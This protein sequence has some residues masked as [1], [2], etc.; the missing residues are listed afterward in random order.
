MYAPEAVSRLKQ[1][2]ERIQTGEN[3]E[4]ADIE[5]AR[6]EVL[7]RY[8]QIFSLDHLSDLTA[9]EF[10]NFLLFRN[11]HHWKPIHRQGNQI[12]ENMDNLRE[13]LRI[14]LDE[15]M[16]IEKRLQI[17]RPSNGEPKVKGL[18]RSVITPILLVSFPNKYGVLN[19]VAENGLKELGLWPELERGA[20]F[21]AKY[22]AVNKIL[23]NLAEEL[24]ID[25]WTLDALWWGIEPAGKDPET[26]IT[27]D[28]SVEGENCFG[29]EKYLH[30]FLF[31]NWGN[32]DLGKD[33]DLLE[34]DG[35]VVGSKYNTGEVGE[36]D[37][38]CKHKNK[39]QWLIIELKRGRSCD[40]AVGQVLRY[41]GWV[42]R[43]LASDEESVR[44]LIISHKTDPKLHYALDG[45]DGIDVLTYSVSFSLHTPTDP[46]TTHESQYD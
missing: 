26:E 10:K 43:H 45:I 28:Q 17:L 42:K 38:L 7:P 21:A 30:E 40:T 9:D 14:L 6:E 46:W 36:I 20:D 31:D 22:I 29:L 19:Q 2:S 27:A 32:T 35:E 24:K 13:A 15:E 1:V 18:A 34:E 33:W 3:Q 12:V 8:Q 39:P 41:R 25:L 37:I 4:L 5:A 23:L 11:N 16:N 44:G